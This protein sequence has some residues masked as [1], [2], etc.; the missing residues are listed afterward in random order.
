MIRNGN[1]QVVKIDGFPIDASM[2][3]D[4][5][6]NSEISTHPVETGTDIT[7]HVRNLPITINLECV[8][9]DTPI[10]EFV[11][12]R[13]PGSTPSADAYGFLKSVRD[14]R[15]PV[16]IETSLEVFDNMVLTTLSIP[17]TA[18]TGDAIQF[19]C[20]FTEVQVVTNNRTTIPTA[21]PRHQRK[22]NRGN[23][24]ITPMQLTTTAL[25]ATSNGINNALSIV[26]AGGSFPSLP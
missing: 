22:Q 13:S 20:S 12:F 1:F 9:S 17:R 24:P 25:R 14:A 6:F 15:Q 23:K 18:E 10:G 4:H 26:G 3:E 16:T 5:A 7:D 21:A 8:V 19:T 11:N 2:S